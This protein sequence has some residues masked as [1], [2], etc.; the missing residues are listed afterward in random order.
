MCL[1]ARQGSKEAG[2]N[3]VIKSLIIYNP[4]QILLRQRLEMRTTFEL[5]NL[6]ERYFSLRSRLTLRQKRKC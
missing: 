4:C 3:Y 5:E 6:K 2:E 1:V